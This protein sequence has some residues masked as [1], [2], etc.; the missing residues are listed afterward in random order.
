MNRAIIK[1]IYN[2]EKDFDEKFFERLSAISGE[3]IRDFSA[4]NINPSQFSIVVVG[5]I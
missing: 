2:Y 1:E 5:G 4:K 3:N